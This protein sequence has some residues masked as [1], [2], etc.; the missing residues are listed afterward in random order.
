MSLYDGLSVETAPI[1]EISVQSSGLDSNS[2]STGNLSGWS[3]GMKLM[4]SQLQRNKKA[5]KATQ[6]KFRPQ[7]STTVL[8]TSTIVQPPPVH[9]VVKPNDLADLGEDDL[10][11]EIVDEYDPL[12][13]NNYEVI[14]R[15]RRE[16]QDKARDE[17]R[18][19]RREERELERERRQRH[20]RHSSSSSDSSDDE[21]RAKRSK[22]KD[23]AAIPPPTSLTTSEP[24]EKDVVESALE[25]L[26][27]TKAQKSNPFSK[28]KFGSVASQIMSKYGWKEGQ[29]LGRQSQGISTALAVEKTSKRGG[30][31]VNLSAEREQQL[32]EDK[33]KAQSLADIMRKPTKV[34]LLQNMV[35]PGE[36]DDDLQPE[37]IEECS[38]YGEVNNCLI[39]EVCGVYYLLDVLFKY[40]PLKM[41]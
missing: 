1:P 28:P 35:G 30:K 17:E 11:V 4:A 29:G 13:P 14:V 21:E 26:S 19:R 6:Q 41:V 34:V 23:S 7:P 27:R 8:E 33:K 15:E 9:V 39:F 16:Q 25:E 37:V 22:R 10:V 31:I 36:V 38:K 40:S 3:S 2:G 12:V 24:E 18:Q 32:E 5:S 20:R